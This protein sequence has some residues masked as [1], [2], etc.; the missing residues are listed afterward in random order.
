MNR[1][2]MAKMTKI[3]IV[4]AG[5]DAPAIRDL[6]ERAG[7]SGYTSVSG[8]SGVGHHG[9]H[10]GRLLFNDH[11]ALEFL[12]TVVPDDRADALLDGLRAVLEAGSGVMFVSDT[13]VSRPE[14]FT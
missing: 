11:A 9:A 10:Q 8:V 12:I 4:T 2:D 14:Y 1:Q 13:Y 6:V 7:A 3:E 5:Q